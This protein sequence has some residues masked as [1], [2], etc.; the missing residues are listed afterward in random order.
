M[1][2]ERWCWLWTWGLGPGDAERG[3]SGVDRLE[4]E[5]IDGSL[6]GELDAWDEHTLVIELDVNND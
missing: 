1:R 6:E 4:E 3:V 5:W 2:V